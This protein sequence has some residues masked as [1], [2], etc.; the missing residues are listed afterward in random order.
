MSLQRVLYGLFFAMVLVIAALFVYVNY[1]EAIDDHREMDDGDQK[2]GIAIDIDFEYNN[3]KR[4]VCTKREDSIEVH[5]KMDRKESIDKTMILFVKG[6]NSNTK[7]Q[8]QQDLSEV[9]VSNDQNSPIAKFK[10]N[11]PNPL[12]SKDVMISYELR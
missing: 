6:I 2:K 9:E 3:V 12:Q 7:K 4:F 5:L 1:Q 10:F 8:F 11:I